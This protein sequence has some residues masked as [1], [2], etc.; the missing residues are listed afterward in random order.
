[1]IQIMAG[2]PQMKLLTTLLTASIVDNIDEISYHLWIYDKYFYR[3][4]YFHICCHKNLD[5]RVAL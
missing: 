3:L 5:F 1:M 4:T 2:T